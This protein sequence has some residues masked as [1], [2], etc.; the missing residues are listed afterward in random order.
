MIRFIGVCIVRKRYE[1]GLEGDESFGDPPQTSALVVS[2]KRAVA[3]D[4]RG[5]SSPVAKKKTG[6]DSA[7]SL[8]PHLCRAW[9]T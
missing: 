5:E 9:W 3:D 8:P 4:Q 1:R 2:K 6:D 7:L